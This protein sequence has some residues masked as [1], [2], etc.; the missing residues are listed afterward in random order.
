[1]IDMPGEAKSY[2]IKQWSKLSN[3]TRKKNSHKT[4]Q[5]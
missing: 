2:K 5:R 3:G 4:K 1:M